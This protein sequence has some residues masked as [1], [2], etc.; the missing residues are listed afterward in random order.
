MN[1]LQE[2]ILDTAVAHYHEPRQAGEPER[3]PRRS[4]NYAV[5]K[6][7]E[8]A[9]HFEGADGNVTV[10]YGQDRALYEEYGPAGSGTAP[11]WWKDVP[12][13]E[14]TRFRIFYRGDDEA[15]K[16]KP[17]HKVINVMAVIGALPVGIF[18]RDDLDSYDHR[19]R[20]SAHFVLHDAAPI[21]GALEERIRQ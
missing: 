14:G 7:L 8:G 5:L 19:G 3:N 6:Y 9:D 4:L 13:T 17:P 10:G 20:L 12:P 2:A 15:E 11:E 18:P 1:E 21:I 16:P